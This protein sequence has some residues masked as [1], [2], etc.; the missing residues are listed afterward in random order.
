MPCWNQQTGA[1]HVCAQG[2]PQENIGE[3]ASL[4]FVVGEV[5]LPLSLDVSAVSGSSVPSLLQSLLYNE[6]DQRLYAVDQSTQGLV[7]I[8]LRSLGIQQTFR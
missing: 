1:C 7:R 8:R 3:A 6:I 4:E 2:N 5:P